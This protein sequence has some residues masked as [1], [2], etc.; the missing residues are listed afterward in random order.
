M[1][2]LTRDFIRHSGFQPNKINVASIL[3]HRK[4]LVPLVPVNFL[5]CCL[6]NHLEILGRHI[7]DSVGRI[8]HIDFHHVVLQREIFGIF[9]VYRNATESL[10]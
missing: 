2:F 1:Q 4:Y 9:D 3:I 7:N 6:V 8:F 5:V 10:L